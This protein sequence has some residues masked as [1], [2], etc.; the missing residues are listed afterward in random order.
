MLCFDSA[1]VTK[2]VQ[3]IVWTATLLE[4]ENAEPM[5]QKLIDISKRL[6]LSVLIEKSSLVIGNYDLPI[7]MQTEYLSERIIDIGEGVSDE[8]I[9]IEETIANTIEEME[10]ENVYIKTGLRELDNLVGGI[11]LKRF[12]LIASRPSVGKTALALS[13]LKNIGYDCNIPCLFYTIEM[14]DT[15]LMFRLLSQITGIDNKYLENRGATLKNNDTIKN[16]FS[17]Y[18]N[19]KIFIDHKNGQKLATFRRTLKKYVK[20]FGIKVCFIDYIQLMRCS[21]RPLREQMVEIS[22]EMKILAK[23]LNIAIVGMAQFNR[24]GANEK[25]RNMPS[26]LKES[27]SLEQDADLIITIERPYADNREE[28]YDGKADV[29]GCTAYLHIDKN[30]SGRRGKVLVEYVG[31]LTQFKDLINDNN[32]YTPEAF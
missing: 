28:F 13:L 26:D 11:G 16:F 22:A 25:R 21:D 20:R 27:G 12:W 3:D 1:D 10:S 5:Y 6:K 17:E 4:F 14:P 19:K 8:L 7:E 30:R 23:E 9:E 29:N 2:Q 32:K 24:T 31:K 18:A 15:E